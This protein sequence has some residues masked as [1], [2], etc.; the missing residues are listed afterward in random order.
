[1]YIKYIN[2][3]NPNR[4][5]GSG[6]SNVAS[7]QIDLLEHQF[8]TEISTRSAIVNNEVILYHQLESDPFVSI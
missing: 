3:E 1:M 5:F 8:C 2:K 7:G 4:I 6:L